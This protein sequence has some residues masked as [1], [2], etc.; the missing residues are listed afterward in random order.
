M[1][2]HFN[3]IHSN[4]ILKDIRILQYKSE[5]DNNGT[6][7]KIKKDM[8]KL[9][10]KEAQWNQCQKQLLCWFIE[11]HIWTPTQWI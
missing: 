1:K 8:Q 3:V 10:F 4:V 5:W 7:A 9:Q 6:T 2:K 11:F